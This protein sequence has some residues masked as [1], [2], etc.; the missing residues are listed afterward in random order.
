MTKV[1][2][3]RGKIVNMAQG[4]SFL[5]TGDFLALLT[6]YAAAARAEGAEQEGE[7]IRKAAF[8]FGYDS[9][10]KWTLT[11]VLHSIFPEQEP[12]SSF[13]KLGSVLAPKET[14]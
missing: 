7:R 12:H 10:R 5:E 2:E 1:E 11:E 9:T 8:A 14:K 4:V 13:P 3:L 6:A